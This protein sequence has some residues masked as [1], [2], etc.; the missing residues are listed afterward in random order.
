MYIVSQCDAFVGGQVCG[1]D[2]VMLMPNN[3]KDTYIFQ[4]GV[5]TQRDINVNETAEKVD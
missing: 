2:A 4:L 5:V 3:F 1:T